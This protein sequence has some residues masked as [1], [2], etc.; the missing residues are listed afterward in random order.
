MLATRMGMG[1]GAALELSY[2]HE[3]WRAGAGFVGPLTGTSIST[4]QGKAEVR[5]E[6][7]WVEGGY[8][9]WRNQ[10]L[11]IEATLAVGV[12]HLSASG[13]V[14]PPWIGRSD[15]LWSAALAPGIGARLRLSDSASLG[16][17]AR[18]VFLTP[19]PFVQ[20]AED[21]RP[22]GMPVLL[23]TLGLQVGF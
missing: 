4:Q 15:Q 12:H 10:L 19:R 7:G 6:L 5:Q 13:S 20:F 2:R 8:S 23:A 21:R 14:T 22:L 18:P 1:W 11:G 16:L 3:A 17:A 9:P